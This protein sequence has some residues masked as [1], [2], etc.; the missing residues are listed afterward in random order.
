MFFTL[1]YG[2]DIDM[3]NTALSYS[4]VIVTVAVALITL[5]TAL[6]RRDRALWIYAAGFNAA[7]VSF[8]LFPG[9]GR[10]SPWIS[11]ILANM[12][13]C[14]FQ[15]CM[16]WGIRTFYAYAKPWAFR[17]WLYGALVFILLL[18]F[19]FVGH[20]YQTR[21]IIVSAFIVLCA[22]EFGKVL[23]AGFTD[24]PQVIRHPMIAF[25][26]AVVA[27]NIV[28]II[29][30]LHD[31]FP[32]YF[33]MDPSPITT[34]TFTYIL[35]SVVIWAGIV[36]TLDGA[37]LM[38]EI[39]KKNKLL[40]NLALKD[41]LTGV[42]N[43]HCLDQTILAEME[44]QDR[45]REPLSLV[46]LDL[47]YFKNVN[48]QYGHDIGDSVLTQT[49]QRVGAAIRETD[50]LFR[51]GGEEF[52]ILMPHTDSAGAV[53]LAEKLRQAIADKPVL[54]AGIVTGSFGVA[55]RFPG[56]SRIGW[57]RR[58]DAAVYRAKNTGRNR[59]EAWSEG[60]HMSPATVRIE[61][62]K[63]WESGMPEIDDQ[64]RAIIRMGNELL[65][66][67][68]SGVPA[69][70]R[71]TLV[72]SLLEHIRLHFTDEELILERVGYPEKERHAEIHKTLYADALNLKEKFLCGD[73]ETSLLFYFIVDKVVVGHML[74]E[75]VQ[76][77]PYTRRQQL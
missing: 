46:M 40:E 17:F 25:V 71:L 1:R 24:M 49:A 15:L 41:E 63:D 75:D 32:G 14:V 16:V 73:V 48:D 8:M 37:R 67:S 20:G 58:V 10:V 66:M 74:T 35:F 61:W 3:W 28:R 56:E 21:A 19:T 70:Q 2:I 47:D 45:Y 29:L 77:F 34:L 57:F 72:D 44:R 51:W 68:L 43:R 62:Q 33:F 31:V 50:L 54:V 30:L 53:I 12:L 52:L 22:V 76:F 38:N 9:Q 13:L 55:E 39:Q 27:F 59:V 23:F 11:V 5:V 64:H 7:A 6:G 18:Y 65:N 36:M 4:V 26:T 42:F 69:G 60:L